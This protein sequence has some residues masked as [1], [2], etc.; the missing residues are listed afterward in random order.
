MYR[1]HKRLSEPGSAPGTLRAPAERRVENVTVTVL[2]YAP[3]Q[4]VETRCSSIEETL[5][6]LREDAP[7]VTWI[8]VAGIH[9]IEGLEALGQRFGLHPLTL[10]D[11]VNSGQ[12]PK[13]E[14][15]DDYL[16]IV[17]RVI[18]S[19]EVVAGEQISMYLGRGWVLTFEEIPED[20][21]DLVRE[22]IRRAK[23]QIRSAGADYLAY[24][25]VDAVVDHYFPVLEK[26]GERLEML[27]D[28]LVEDPGRQTLEKIHQLKRE[29]L[30]LRRAAWPQ[31]EVISTLGRQETDLVRR[32]TRVFLRDCYDHTIQ[33]MD[34]VETY[35]DLASSMMDLYLS[36]VSNRTN[37]IMKVLTVIASIFIPLTFIAGVYGMNF[38]HQA[39]PLN[40]PELSW[41]WGYPVLWLV[42]IGLAAGMFT[43]FRR[44]RWI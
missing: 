2:T 40:M 14:D 22:R 37:E 11:V 5:A 10:E 18:H 43:Y 29:L 8:H 41:Y 42:M 19:A 21:F 6:A 23:G 24:A 20:A 36:S 31:R 33:I 35:R 32:E 4:L 34:L 9:E 13:L 17:M 26:L 1:P 12:R 25:I 38:D 30:Q 39:S 27:E 28:E 7:G 15:Y 16:F 3:D 44:Q